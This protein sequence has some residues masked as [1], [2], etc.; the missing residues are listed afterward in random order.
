[1]GLVRVVQRFFHGRDLNLHAAAVTFYG[2]VAVVPVA[3]LTVKLAGLIAGADR[4]RELAGPVIEAMPDRLGADH[5]TAL[6]FDAGLRMSWPLTL[7]ALFPATW[8]GEGLRRAFVSLAVPG[9]DGAPVAGWRGRLLILPVLAVAPALLL[10]LLL[11]LTSAA[12]RLQDGGWSGVGAVVASFL[13]AW[14]ALSPAFVM[15]YRWCAPPTPAWAPTIVVGSFTAANVSGFAHGFVL[16]WSLPLD[17]GVPFGGLDAV[18]AVV[19]VLLWLYVLHLLT[20]IGYG[21]TLQASRWW[22]L[23]SAES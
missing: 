17:L 11:V 23:R 9:T 13:A 6:L 14:L 2:A 15:V 16:F 5:A 1:M 3:L 12:R 19:A 7:T 21:A 18:G 8:Y 20:L 10:G 4:I 22:A